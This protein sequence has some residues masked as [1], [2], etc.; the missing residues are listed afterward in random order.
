MFIVCSE[1]IEDA[2]FRSRKI[3]WWSNVYG[4]D[5]S[6]IGE[7]ARREPLSIIFASYFSLVDTVESQQVC[8]NAYKLFEIDMYKVKADNLSWDASYELFMLRN[9]YIHGFEFYFNVEFTNTNIFFSTSPHS[10]Y[11]HC[12]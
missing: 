4:F 9:D 3:D 1:A 11:T 10:K 2:E 8:T 7:I 12:M 5:M 6:N